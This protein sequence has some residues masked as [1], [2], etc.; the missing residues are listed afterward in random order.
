MLA[1]RYKSVPSTGELQHRDYDVA[2]VWAKAESLFWPS[3]L[4]L[5]DQS[6]RV[7]CFY[8]CYPL[9]MKINKL[10]ILWY[11]KHWPSCTSKT[12]RHS[13]RSFKLLIPVVRPNELQALHC[14]C[15]SM[16]YN[17]FYVD[18]CPRG[19]SANRASAVLRTILGFVD[20][21]NVYWLLFFNNIDS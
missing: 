3:C 18:A 16:K 14:R 6:S 19:K 15:I 9:S 17:A 11:Y 21:N 1:V 4:E 7:Q 10:Q 12:E 2:T 8:P 5:F 20:K 13:S